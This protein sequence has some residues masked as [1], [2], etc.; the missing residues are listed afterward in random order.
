MSLIDYFTGL[1]LGAYLGIVF[2]NLYLD[3]ESL[4]NRK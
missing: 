4:K 3:I 2:M 1:G